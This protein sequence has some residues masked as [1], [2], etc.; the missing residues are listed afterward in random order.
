M[1]E[2]LKAI[3]DD[4]LENA[5]KLINKDNINFVDE[6]RRNILMNY[7]LS[8]SDDKDIDFINFLLKLGININH[9][10]KK[11][12]WSVLHFS[13]QDKNYSICELLLKYGA[14]SNNQDIFGNTPLSKISSM[15]SELDIRLIKLFLKYGANPKIKNNFGN[16]PLDTA[17]LI[18]NKNIID[19]LK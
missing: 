2:I 3:R 10:D 9:K 13:A 15:G 14:D 4:N 11:Q 5:K 8:F 7:I 17:Y 1:D 6:D 19:L 18:E 12:M 16:S